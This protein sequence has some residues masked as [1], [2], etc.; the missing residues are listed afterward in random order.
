MNIAGAWHGN[1]EGYHGPPYYEKK[2][3]D[4][5][6]VIWISNKHFSFYNG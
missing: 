2:K 6:T 5:I 3:D 1:K 4:D